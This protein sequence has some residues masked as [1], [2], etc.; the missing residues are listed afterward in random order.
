[1]YLNLL[2][3]AW[4]KLLHPYLHARALA[5]FAVLLACVSLC[6]HDLS[7]IA[8]IQHFAKVQ[9]AKRHTQW[10]LHVGGTGFLVLP[11]VTA[12]TKVFE[13][14]EWVLSGSILSSELTHRR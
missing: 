5:V 2:N 9:L 11:A 7:Q 6:A 8:D 14:A 3:K 13:N 4:R 10:D 12:K 1:M